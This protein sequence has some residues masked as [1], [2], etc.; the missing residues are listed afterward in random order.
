M[1]FR[2]GGEGQGENPG[3]A[4][5]EFARRLAALHRAAGLPSL[6]NV[7][8]LAQRRGE[9]DHRS[10][11]A[12]AQRIS[13]WVSGRNVP[14]RFES[15]V[16][17]LQV[18]G[19]R[20][21]RRAGTP[22]ETINL[23]AWRML[24][25]AARAT[26]VASAGGPGAPYPD[27][28]GFSEA[29]ESVFFGR[30]RA[31][32]GLLEMIRASA[33]SDR[34]ARPIVL[35]GASGVGKSALLHAGVVPALRAEPGRWAI[36]AMVPGRDPLGTLARIFGG[37]SDFAL[38]DLDAQTIARWSGGRRPLLIV[39]QFEQLY[40]PELDPAAREGFLRWL[41]RLTAVG[42]VLV[43]IRS[44]QVVHCSEPSWLS[45]ALQHNSFT[46]TPMRRQELV[47][48]IVGP[49]RTRGV[50]VDPGVV[51][52][53]IA[54]LDGGRAVPARPADAGA[55]PVLS[56]AMRSMWAR[57]S[58]ERLDIATY[59]RV[60]GV[61][62]VVGQL[63]ER[64]WAGLTERERL[65]AQQVLLALV[66]VHRDGT[67]V[68]RRAPLADLD[69]LA[70][71]S[72][73]DLVERLVRARLVTLAARHAVLAHDALL[74]WDRLRNLIATNRTMLIWRQRI[75]D[76]AAEWEA[77]DRDPGLLYRGVR[78]TSAIR[79]ADPSLSPAATRFLRACA[80]TELGGSEESGRVD[81][82]EEAAAR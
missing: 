53:L 47:S 35:T 11:V 42:S 18:L 38:A 62:G 21:R 25:S 5:N 26:P 13:D 60:G 58:G 59:R 3:S 72:G 52:L 71:G 6:R 28:A 41:D 77:A 44:D 14:A 12:T 37:S 9:G 33:D 80:R 29:H 78:L 16:P 51:D 22:S 49:P 66:T 20:A 1:E 7:A 56:T 61:A 81:E 65:D 15:L 46:L 74:D 73:P 64:Y 34:P 79:S 75:E 2:S 69:G 68:R 40:R 57:R 24:W 32:S 23:R 43:S 31:L 8:M 48:A 45:N 67:V 17:V 54:S 39:D 70:A 27:A 30:R 19:S 10:A 55:L 4:R 36:A 82:Y 76:D 63:A 50:T